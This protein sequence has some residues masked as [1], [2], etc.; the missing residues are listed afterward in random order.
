MS[1]IPFHYTIAEKVMNLLE[2]GTHRNTAVD[3][4]DNGQIVQ[5]EIETKSFQLSGEIFIASADVYDSLNLA[6]IKVLIRI[7]QELKMN[8]PL[9]HC[10]DK[11]SGQLRSALAQLK[12]KGI[13][14]PIDGTDMFIVNPTKIRKGRPLAVYGALYTYAKRMYLKDKKW[15]PTTEDIIRL[16]SP[17]GISMS[18]VTLDADP[19]FE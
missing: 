9:W 10:P 4:L 17:K 13:I 7:Q 15:V 3:R 1:K 2:Q 16:T 8:N 6:A 14:E 11:S 5:I 12:R 18:D 19:N